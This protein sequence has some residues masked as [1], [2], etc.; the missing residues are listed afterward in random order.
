LRNCA[1]YAKHDGLVDKYGLKRFNLLAK[2]DKMLERFAMQ[3]KLR[4]YHCKL[5]WKFVVR[6]PYNLGKASGID[7]TNS[8]IY[9][10]DFEPLDISHPMEFMIFLGQ[11]NEV[12][13]ANGL[14][15]VC[16]QFVYDVKHDNHE[17][18]NIESGKSIKFVLSLFSYMVY[19]G[20]S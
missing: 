14:K 4:S 16:C 9:F 15:R 6:V 8:D 11:E 2:D 19:N 5:F 13:A 20:L 10:Q 18:A 12:K 17:M 7:Q 3:T 1:I